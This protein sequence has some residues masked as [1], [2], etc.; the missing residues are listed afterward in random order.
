MSAKSLF[1]IKSETCSNCGICAE[2]CPALLFEKDDSDKIRFKPDFLNLCIG[3]GHCMA[4]CKTKSVFANGFSYDT[5]FFEYSETNDL[6][7]LMEHRRSVRR[8]KPKPV[9]KEALEKILSAISQ[10]PHGDAHH[11]VEVTVINNRDKIM[12]AL[13]SMETFYS[14]LEKWLHNPFIRKVI[15]LEK[16]KA[17]I[18]TLKN[19]LLPRIEKD[20]YKHA[21]YEYDG[22]TRGAH[23]LFI[24]HA[25]KYAEEH[26]EDA[27]ILVSYATLAAQQLGLGSTIIGLIPAALNKTSGLRRIFHIP[28]DHDSVIAL[29]IGYPKYKYHRGI[30]RELRNI[31]WI[32]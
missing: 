10:V 14:K 8:F 21:S 23:T 31:N 3:C 1:Y 12:E 2:V 11:H 22:I 16:G 19:H 26:I 29:I 32:N 25:H 17:T 30:R 6:F 27:L 24:F 20:I 15:E 4:A 7:S 28:D 13:P 18:N 5:D 9:E